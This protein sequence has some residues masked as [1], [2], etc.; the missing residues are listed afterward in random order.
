MR[1]V[2]VGG[3]ASRQQHH[4]LIRVD[5]PQLVDK[6]RIAIAG[7]PGVVHKQ[8]GPFDL[9]TR[10][11]TKN[12][13]STS[14][15]RSGALL[16]FVT[17]ASQLLDLDVRLVWIVMDDQHAGH[18]KRSFPPPVGLPKMSGRWAAR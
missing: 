9:P 14:S 13:A 18:D 5:G 12:R 6:L 17:C 4:R 8:V 3:Q 7:D 2:V 15:D 11:T 16:D 1:A 10:L